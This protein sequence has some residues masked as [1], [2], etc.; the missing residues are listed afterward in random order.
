[1][2]LQ[3][4]PY[5]GSFA[6]SS[7]RQQTAVDVAESSTQQDASD[8]LAA[9]DD[10]LQ[11]MSR[12]RMQNARQSQIEQDN[13]PRPSSQPS[14]SRLHSSRKQDRHDAGSLPARSQGM[15]AEGS[16]ITLSGLSSEASQSHAG[17]AQ[18]RSRLVATSSL[19]QTYRAHMLAPQSL[20]EKLNSTN[21]ASLQH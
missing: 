18:Q 21:G 5:Q 3:Q 16:A 17:Q 9:A 8:A 20:Q 2:P 10:L 6:A 11:A 13:N 15:Q 4:L 14:S 1:M 12:R 7:P 19:R